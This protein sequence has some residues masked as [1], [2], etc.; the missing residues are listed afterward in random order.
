MPRKRR[1]APVSYRPPERLRQEFHDRVLN[2][3]LSVNAFLTR[4]VFGLAAP[5]ARR[6]SP[7]DQQMAAVLLSQA[8][9]IS[10]RLGQFNGVAGSGEPTQDA[11]L[12][13]CHDELSAIRTCLMAAL[14]RE[15]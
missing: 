5:R 3:G 7:V 8:A 13:A 12:K 4:A 6:T 2:S 14:G 11:L 15:R 10:D 9:R 1:H